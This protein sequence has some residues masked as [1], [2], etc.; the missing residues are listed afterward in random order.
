MT[1]ARPNGSWTGSRPN[2]ARSPSPAP[3]M[4]FQPPRPRASAAPTTDNSRAAEARE[5]RGGTTGVLL[6]RWPWIVLVTMLVVVG[7]AL[8]SW[9]KTPKYSSSASVAIPP[10]VLAAGTAPVLPNMGTELA[11]A[12]SALVR[13]IAA[14]HLGV[15][16]AGLGSGLSISVPLNENVLQFKVSSPDPSAAQRRAQAFADAYVTYWKQQ[17]AATNQSI[18]K[19]W[20]SNLQATVIDFATL[21]RYPSTPRH[22]IDVIIGVLIGLTLGVGTAWVRDRLDDRLRGSADL[23]SRAGTAVLARI[24]AFGRRHQGHP[25]I[26]VA[27]P[28]ALASL[29]YQ[30]LRRTTL[31]LAAERSAKTLLVVTPTGDRGRFIAVNTAVAMARTLPRVIL[32]C[33]D[34]KSAER[35]HPLGVRTGPGLGDVL[36]RRASLASAVHPCDIG[37]LHVLPFGT[38]VH[39]PVATFDGPAMRKLFRQLHGM[40]DFVV[41]DGAGV[42]A[43]PYMASFA[44]AIEMILLVADGA[45]TTRHEVTSARAWLD[46]FDDQLIGCVLDNA[47]PRIGHRD[48]ASQPAGSSAEL[49]GDDH[50]PGHT[51]S[52]GRER[53]GGYDATPSGTSPQPHVPLPF[54]DTTGVD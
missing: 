30:D 48:A 6:L 15:S 34:P 9:S 44:D 38:V 52:H 13:K 4:A 40:A 7:A 46:Q 54:D 51:A 41:V 5:R 8:M 22:L 42:L 36:E 11:V 39:D 50:R 17:Q 2:G 29:A 33:A 21:P 47:G 53:F 16:A 18:S 31:R 12:E 27:K 35:P 25:L 10:Q 37:N 14:S 43:D 23:G 24:P 49:T 3:Q 45:R 32:V 28:F 26:T 20:R 1:E 19:G